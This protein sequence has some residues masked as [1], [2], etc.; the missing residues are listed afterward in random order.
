MQGYLKKAGIRLNVN[1]TDNSGDFLKKG[2]WDIYSKAIVTA[3]TGDPQYYIAN[4]FTA[5][6][7]HND[8]RYRNPRVDALVQRFSGEF[9]PERRGQLAIAI[10][11]QVLDDHA[12]LYAGH[13][14]MNLVMRN[15]VQ[16]FVPH[17]C[18]YY[19]VTKDLDVPG[20]GR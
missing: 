17:P 6:S 12:F 1:A 2:D 4:H 7:A 9:D 14:R 15:G 13:L 10:V 8:G 20:E 3:P 5:Q 19:E 11:Q 18:D 16:G